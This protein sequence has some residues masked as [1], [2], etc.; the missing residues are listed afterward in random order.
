MGVTANNV[1]NL[2]TGGFKKSK[3]AIR[4][5][6]DSYPEAGIYKIESKGDIVYEKGGNGR[7]KERELSNVDLTEEIHQS[8]VTQRGYEANLKFMK[9]MD[10]TL[11]SILDIIG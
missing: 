4:E 5:G 3:V 2:D 1:A 10:D 6:L 11:R 8:I 7:M 9:D